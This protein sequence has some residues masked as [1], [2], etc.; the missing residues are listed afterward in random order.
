MKSIAD[1]KAIRDKMQSQVFT[2]EKTDDNITRIVVGMATCGIAAGARPVFNELVE[3]VAAR[4]LHNVVV[5]RSGCLGMC[6]LEPIVEVFVPGEEKVTYVKVDAEKAKKI[7]EKHIVA[8]MV[9]T[10]YLV[11]EE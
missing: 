2:R 7:I 1:I 6:K 4:G 5:S 8:G 9:C 10:D 11:G 3:Q